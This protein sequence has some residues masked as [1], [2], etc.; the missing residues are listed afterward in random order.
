MKKQLFN[1]LFTF[2]FISFSSSL[3]GQAKTEL[4]KELN[5]LGFTSTN[6][7]YYLYK[8]KETPYSCKTNGGT[9]VF[10]PFIAILK[11]ESNEKTVDLLKENP[12]HYPVVLPSSTPFNQTQT[13]LIV[14]NKSTINWK[15]ENEELIEECRMLTPQKEA[16]SATEQIAKILAIARN[17]FE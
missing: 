7:A 6:E 9:K 16:L 3:Y 12:L 13:K 1:L 2:L 10:Y 5:Q 17:I 14:T 8:L 11:S 4:T 15:I